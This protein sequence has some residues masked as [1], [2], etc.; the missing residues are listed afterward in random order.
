[1][2]PG[3]I[4]NCVS[5]LV[6]F[7]PSLGGGQS[8]CGYLLGAVRDNLPGVVPTLDL[9]VVWPRFWLLF[10]YGRSNGRYYFCVSAL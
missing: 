2:R 5:P 1:V 9:V 6:R 7:I 3:I 4:M 8:V 10:A